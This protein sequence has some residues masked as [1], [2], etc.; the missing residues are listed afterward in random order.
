VFPAVTWISSRDQPSL[1]PGTWL[2]ASDISRN[3]KLLATKG[4]SLEVVAVRDKGV[5]MVTADGSHFVAEGVEIDPV[6]AWDRSLAAVPSPSAL[7]DESAEPTRR[8]DRDASEIFDHFRKLGELHKEG[9]LSDDEFQAKKAE[10]LAR[11]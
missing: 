6:E 4:Q 2:A 3:G 10:L 8:P 7:E 9:T 11:L 5:D 1:G